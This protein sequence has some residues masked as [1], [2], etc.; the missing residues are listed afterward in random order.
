MNSAQDLPSKLPREE[1]ESLNLEDQPVKK[2]P[3]H[4]DLTKLF[5]NPLYL[6][7]PVQ[8]QQTQEETNV[9]S[10][11]GPELLHFFL[12]NETKH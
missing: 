1:D 5:S 7:D 8:K 2:E 4:A 10:A 12:S 3:N 11:T 6:R 9:K